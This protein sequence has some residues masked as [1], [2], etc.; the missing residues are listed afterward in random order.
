LTLRVRVEPA[1]RLSAVALMSCDLPFDS[2]EVTR[3]TSNARSP[4]AA[5]FTDSTTPCTTLPAGNGAIVPT[6]TAS[7]TWPI[8][9]CPTDA[10][11]DVSA[12]PMVILTPVPAATVAEGASG[13][14][15]GFGFACGGGAGGGVG[16]G[17]GGLG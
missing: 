3:S 10:V 17:V 8:H 2:I 11:S 5:G 7:D 14:G 6:V 4:F 12:V 15:L 13:A 1:I 9:S 16:G